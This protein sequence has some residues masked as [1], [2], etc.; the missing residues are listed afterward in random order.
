MSSP[1]VSVVIPAHNAAEFVGD[2]IDSVLQQ[3][4]RHYEI[5]VIDDGSSDAT[6]SIVA[7][8]SGVRLL[9][10]PQRGAGAARN[11]GI[12]SSKGELIAFLDAD[13]W[14]TPD[15]LER[16]VA[17][18]AS[19]PDVG[20]VVSEHINVHTNA[21]SFVTDK[22]STFDGDAVRGIFL[23]SMV[24][25][26]TVMVRRGVLHAVGLFDESLRC[27][28]DE[29]LWMRIALKYPI[30]LLPAPLA[31]VRIRADSL[32]RDNAA[33]SAAVH[34]HLD[35]LPQRYPEI[36]R[37][38]GAL[39]EMRRAALF[40]STGLHALAHEKFAAARQAFANSFR[41]RPGLKAATYWL[42]CLLPQ[43]A[44]RAARFVR[45]TVSQVVARSRT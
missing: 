15:K 36:A 42:S 29:N 28:E 26:P 30:V 5:L 37:R 23:N 43:R 22:R 16:Q 21:P 8:Y 19:R 45:R 24:G 11:A 35:L 31:H 6:A 9:R 4:Y 25:T 1:L 34:R 3:S 2:A 17:L 27:A 13:D 32:S 44:F 38:L 14:W 39:I 33:L 7:R 12:R 40:F 10:Q 18:L 41:T 20:M